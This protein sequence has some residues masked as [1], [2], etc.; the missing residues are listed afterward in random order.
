MTY[1]TIEDRQPQLDVLY[2]TIFP[3]APSRN[4]N[5]E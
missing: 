3:E 5:H 2:A 4:G 1:A